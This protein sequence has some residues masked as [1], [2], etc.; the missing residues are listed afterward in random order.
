MQSQRVL[1]YVASPTR[2]GNVLV[3]MSRE[4]VVDVVLYG[5]ETTPS[6]LLLS[7]RARFPRTALLPDEG[8][9]SSWV[10]A[11]VAHL[12]GARPELGVPVDLAWSAAPA[13]MDAAVVPAFDRAS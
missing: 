10:A 12:E 3:L 7:L 5:R 13:S 8:T 1:R 11:V 4:G 2:F 6:N 9:H